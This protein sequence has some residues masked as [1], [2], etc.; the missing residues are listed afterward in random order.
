M[1][2]KDYGLGGLWLVRLR[3]LGADPQL[4]P[5]P[6]N[7]Y[8]LGEGGVAGTWDLGLGDSGPGSYCR[9]VGNHVFARKHNCNDA[10]LSLSAVSCN[11]QY[12][13]PGLSRWPQAGL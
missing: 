9:W 1:K 7:C 12:V 8:R 13:W 3:R 4:D 10:M 2:C 6:R 5:I 11:S